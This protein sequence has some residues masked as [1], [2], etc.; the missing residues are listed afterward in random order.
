MK[1]SFKKSIEGGRRTKGE[2]ARVLVSR[3]FIFIYESQLR[4]PG[5]LVTYANDSTKESK[6]WLRTGNMFYFD[7]S[8]FLLSK[9]PLLV[10]KLECRNLLNSNALVTMYYI[11]AKPLLSFVIKFREF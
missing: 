10:A 1:K 2:A 7:V 11:D 4:D 8:R 9:L 5:A 3:K 6:I